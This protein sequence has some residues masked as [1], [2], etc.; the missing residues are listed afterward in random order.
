MSALK[1]ILVGI[2]IVILGIGFYNLAKLYSPGSYPYAEEYNVNVNEAKLINSINKFKK[3]NPKYIVPG[4]L[5]LKE[6]RNQVNEHWYSVYFYYPESDEI[7]YA[8]TRPNGPESTT[9]GFVSINHGNHLGNWKD[10]NKDFKSSQNL[11][12]KEKFVNLI[13]N[14]IKEMSTK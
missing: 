10:I 4:R 8:W 9:L 11:M 13:L 12:Q 5:N 3:T 1:R 2:F 6:G 7:I 14:P